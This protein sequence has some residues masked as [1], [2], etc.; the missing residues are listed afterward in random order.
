MLTV[1]IIPAAVEVTVTLD[2]PIG[3]PA[4]EVLPT[5]VPPDV[6]A[7]VPVAA[8]P[9]PARPAAVTASSTPVR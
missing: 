6:P 2:G 9:Q 7:D 5:D 8:P 1:F 3:V 4:T